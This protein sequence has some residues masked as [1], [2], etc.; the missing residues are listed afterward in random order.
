MLKIK[1]WLISS[2]L[3]MSH[4][5]IATEIS[6]VHT[7]ENEGFKHLIEKFSE[8]TGVKIKISWLDQADLKVRI[9]R[10]AE[11]NVTPDVIIVPADHLGLDER[12][13]FSEIPAELISSDINQNTLAT[14]SIN[15]RT[16]G[17]PIISGNHLL[18][19][20]NKKW[21]KEVATDW[22]TLIAQ[23]EQLPKSLHLISW[24]FMEMYWFIPFLTAFDA[25]PIIG[26][27]PNFKNDEVQNALQFVWQLAKQQIVDNLCDYR[28]AFERFSQGESAYTINGVWAFGQFKQ[29]LGDDFGL[30]PL[31]NINHHAMK[32]YYSSYVVAFPKNSLNG[33]KKEI[34]TQFALFMQSEALQNEIMTQLND[35]PVHNKILAKIRQSDN[36]YLKIIIK[37]L[38]QS[39]AMPTNQNMAI[40]WEAMLKGFTR[41]GSGAMNAEKASIYMQKIAERSIARQG[42]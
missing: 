14:A 19:Y 5:S 13:H 21:V 37:A 2:M 40:I 25:K 16:L 34:L 24:S 35:L 17:I 36:Q 6:V 4:V 1:Q 3:F 31:P 28:C 20:Y 8:K 29:S 27:M 22:Q 11:K 15:G 26:V 39:I 18:L 41:Y 9:L 32:S 33:E 30:A 10:S 12:V 42:N 23:R 7:Y 38:D